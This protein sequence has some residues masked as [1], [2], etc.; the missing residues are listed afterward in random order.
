MATMHLWITGMVQGV[1]YRAT[2]AELARKLNLSGWI[3]NA[4][5]GAVEATVSGGDEALHEF[6]V[7]CRKVPEKARVD[8]VIVTPKPDDGLMGFEVIR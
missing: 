3:R 5:D 4:E 7:W 6:V 8:N 2:A 1:F